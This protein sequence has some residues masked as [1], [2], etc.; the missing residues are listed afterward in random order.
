[1]G[2]TEIGGGLPKQPVIDFDH[3][4]QRSLSES[5]L[6]WREVR[7]ECPVAWT[8]AN[9]G[10]WVVSSYQEVA[11]A[12]KDWETFSSARTDPEVCSL[13]VG[14]L[15]IPPLYPEELDPPEWHPLRRMLSELLSPGAVKRMQPRITHWVTYY[16]DQVIES[17]RC[18]LTGD[19]GCPIPAAVSL[20]LLGFPQSD[21]E[22]M[23]N[24]FHGTGSYDRTTPEF[25]R[26]LADVAWVGTRVREEL[27]ARMEA[28]RDDAM[29]FIVS[30]DVD[31]RQ[32]PL[33]DAEAVVLLVVG[34]GVDTTTSLTSS[35]LLYLSRYPELRS[36][37]LADSTI[38]DSGTEEFLRMYPPA[39]THA[40]IAVRDAELGGCHIAT[41]DRVLLSEVSA[42][43]D[44]SAFPNADQFV[45]DRFPNRHV[46][47]GLGIHRCPGSHLARAQFKEIIRQVLERMPDY[48]VD[49]QQVVEYPNWSSIGGW[50]RMPA[51]FGP[52]RRLL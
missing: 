49:Q 30:H 29:S 11:S 9:G 33:A 50:A 42:C 52:G 41:G 10:H 23:S 4:R 31:G 19:I 28:P 15:K 32:I 36:P 35:A 37:L 13:S 26:A 39:R 34:G 5:D 21:W 47:F 46:A 45:V 3:Y 16:I 51:T 25:A 22:R 7:R 2:G 18:D 1:M 43:Y 14:N 48:R 44:E 27:S 6:A 38:L 12:F 8:E 20:E 17:G 40:R 24:A